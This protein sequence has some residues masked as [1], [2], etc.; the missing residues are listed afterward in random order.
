M[1]GKTDTNISSEDRDEQL[2]LIKL[3]NKQ[4]MMWAI[5][6]L[7]CDCDNKEKNAICR[8]AERRYYM[9]C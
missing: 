5:S 7:S 4:F 6:R 2:K 3:T 8:E 1:K 9:S